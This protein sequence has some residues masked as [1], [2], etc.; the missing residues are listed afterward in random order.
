M[1]LR[2]VLLGDS[3]VDVLFLLTLDLKGLNAHVEY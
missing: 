1:D 2:L 3:H